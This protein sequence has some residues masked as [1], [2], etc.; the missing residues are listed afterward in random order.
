MKL[1][2]MPIEIWCVRHGRIV[3]YLRLA[4]MTDGQRSVRRSCR[5]RPAGRPRCAGLSVNNKQA[6]KQENKQASRFII[7][8]AGQ[9]ADH[10]ACKNRCR[11]YTRTLPISLSRAKFVVKVVD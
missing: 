10:T 2:P 8:A 3:V 1:P 4:L 7:Q 5:L 6:N 9:P 11:L